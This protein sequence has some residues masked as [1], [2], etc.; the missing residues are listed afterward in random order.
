[1]PIPNASHTTK[2]ILPP[3]AVGICWAS[4]Y[5]PGGG[6]VDPAIKST[7]LADMAGI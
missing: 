6:V 1:V 7:A 5:H 4:E 2:S 3:S